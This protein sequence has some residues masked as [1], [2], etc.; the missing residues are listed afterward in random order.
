MRI[1]IIQ[2]PTTTCIDGIR[3]D[4]FA[5]GFQYDVGQ[6]LGAYL[7]V[8]G[9]AEPVDESA[10]AVTPFSEAET[11]PADAALP[12]LRREI[13]PPYYD[14]PPSLALDERRRRRRRDT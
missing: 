1:R 8:E 5:A 10:S 12:N 11:E 4:H 2:A 9:W 3:L 13:F 6:T 7:V 14:G